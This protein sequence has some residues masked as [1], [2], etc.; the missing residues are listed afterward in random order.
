MKEARFESSSIHQKEARRACLWKRS[1]SFA[2]ITRRFRRLHGMKQC[3]H[4]GENSISWAYKSIHRL[5][6]SLASANFSL[7]WKYLQLQL[8]LVEHLIAIQKVAGSNPVSCSMW[9]QFSWQ[10]TRLWL[11]LSRIRI[12][13]VT[14]G[15]SAESKRERNYDVIS[16]YLLED[17]KWL[18]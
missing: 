10:N 8:N 15:Q 18:Q 11:W 16:Q 5:R 12:P 14:P 2:Q 9:P 6:H 13:P 1:L 7:S 4:G 3:L 17:K